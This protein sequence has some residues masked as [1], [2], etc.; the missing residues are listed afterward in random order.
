MKAWWDSR[1][2]REQRLLS[3]LA[4][5]VALFAVVFLIVLPVLEARTDAKRALAGA[6]ADYKIVTRTLPAAGGGTAD[7]TPFTRAVLL[8]MARGQGLKITRI[9]ADNSGG[10]AVWIDDAE[11]TR[12]YGLFDR[13]LMNTNA[14]MERVVVSADGVGRL[15]AQFTVR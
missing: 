6:E 9:Q 12:L 8:D 13:L 14:T 4:G 11:T 2:P 3:I 7:R 15:S 5:L 1:E 10:F